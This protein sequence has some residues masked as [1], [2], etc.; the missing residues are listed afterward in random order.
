MSFVI[1]SFRYKRGYHPTGMQCL[2]EVEL[3]ILSQGDS[4]PAGM[5]CLT[6]VESQ[7]GNRPAGMQCLTEVELQ[8]LSQGDNR[9]PGMQCLTE[10]ESQGG[11]H[12]AGMQCLTE[13]E[14]NR[15]AG[16]QCLTEVELQILSQG[17]NRPAGMQCL[18]EVESQGDNCLMQC[19]TEV[20]SQGGNRPA[21]MQCLTEVES[22]GGNRP[23]GMQCESQGGNRPAGMQCLTEVESQEGNRPAGMQCLTEVESQGGN[24]PAGMQCLTEVELQ[25]LSQGSPE[26]LLFCINENEGKFLNTFKMHRYFTNSMHLKRMVKLLY[27]LVKCEDQNTALK[28]L[29]QIIC[30]DDDYAFFAIQIDGVLK[31]MI[32]ETCG[33]VKRENIAF[34]DHLIEIGSMGIKGIP[35]TVEMTFPVTMMERTLKELAATVTVMERTLTEL[36]AFG[37]N[38]ALIS[39]KFEKMKRQFDAMRGRFYVKSY[40]M[41]SGEPP[42]ECFTELPILPKRKKIHIQS[43][44]VFLRANKVK[45]GY[46]SSHCHECGRSGHGRNHGRHAGRR[47]GSRVHP[48]GMQC[49]SEEDLQTLS[50]GNP[51]EVLVSINK[52]EGRFLNTFKMRRY[53][54][55]P[56][57]LKRMVKLLYLLVKC[58]DQSTASKMMAQILCTDGDYASFTTQIDQVLKKMAFETRIYIKRDIAFLDNLIEIGSMAIKAI[59][60]TVGLTF[61]V[62]VMERTIEELTALGENTNLITMKFEEMNSAFKRVKFAAVIEAREKAKLE[63]SKESE[64]APP[65]PFTQLSVLPKREEIHVQSKKVFLRANK[66][67]GGYINCDHYFDVQFR[68]LREDFVRPLREGIG[69]FCDTGSTKKTSDIRVY[70][71]AKI[72]NPVCLFTGIGFQLRFD[73]SKFSRVNWEHSRRLIFGSLLCLSNDNFD[74]C[75]LFAT[76]VKRDPKLIQEGLLTIKFEG[77]VNGFQIDPTETYTMVES[78]AYY[79]AYCHV[80]KSMQEISLHPDAVPMKKYIMECDFTDVQVPVFLHPP[81]MP[82]HFN[83][84][85]ILGKRTAKGHLVLPRKVFNIANP[86]SW[87]QASSTCLDESQLRALKMALTKEVSVIQG[88]P[89][90]GKTYIGL[91]IVEAYLRNRAVWDP[92]RAAPILVVCYT[93]HT[94]DQLLEEIQKI[95]VD[96]ACPS[97]IRVGGRCKSAALENSVLSE[98][99]QE[100]RANRNIPQHLFRDFMDARSALFAS[101]GFINSN[102]K[103]CDAE[104]KQKIIHLFN[105]EVVIDPNHVDQLRYVSAMNKEIEVWLGLWFPEKEE[106]E[107]PEMAIL[108]PHQATHDEV[109]ALFPDTSSS[110]EEYIQVDNEARI[111]QEE[112]MI[113]GE[114]VEVPVRNHD[115]SQ[116]DDTALPKRSKKAGDKHGWKTVQLSESQ[117]K[118]KIG[119]GF[120]NTPMLREEASRVDNIWNLSDKERWQLYLHW[121]N[122]YIRCCKERV[123]TKAQEYNFTCMLYGESQRNIDCHVAQGADV[124]GMTT[125]GAA[126]YHHLLR[127]IHPKV[128]IFEEAAEVLEAHV[129]TSLAS[130]VQQLI[131]IGDHKQLKP[132]PTC[133]DLEKHYHLDTSLFERFINNGFEHVTLEKQHRMRPEISS[134]LCPSIYEKLEDAENVKKYDPVVGVGKDLFFIEHTHPEEPNEFSDMKSHVNKFEAEYVVELCHYLLK[135]GAYSPHDITILTMYRGQL[136]EL[137]KRMKREHFEGV[138]VAAV[139]DFQGEENE[140]ILLSLVRS[141]SDNSIG[142]LS[143]E[144]RVCVSLSRAKKGLYVIGNLCMLRERNDTKWPE[145]IHHLEN[146]QCVGPGLPLYC[147]VHPEDKAQIRTPA[148]F[149]QRPEGGCTKMC[150]MRLDCGHVCERICHPK[151]REHKLVSCSKVCGKNL[152][153]GHTCKAKCYQCKKKLRCRPC[154]EHVQ[155][156]LPYCGHTVTLR[157]SEDTLLTECPL[158]CQKSLPCGH[159][160]QNT[161]SV[162]CTI[163]CMKKVKKSLPCGHN[164]SVPCFE[165]P[166]F[167]VC[168]VKC[169]QMLECGDMCSGTCG[170]CHRGRLHI[171]CRQ[172]CGRDLVCGHLC[173]YQCAS[174]CPPCEEPCNN[175]CLHSK[176]P[177]KCY[178]LCKPCME[179]CEWLCP[180]LQCTKPCGELCNRPPCNK[181]CDKTLKC[182]HP[183]IGLCGERCPSKCRICDEDEVCAIFFGNED[184]EDALFI[185]LQ[186]CG[187]ILEVEGLDQW[188]ET[189]PGSN[190]SS[191]QVQFKTCPK[192]KAFIRKSVRYGN[193]IKQVLS[194]VEKVKHKQMEASDG[195]D[196]ELHKVKKQIQEIGS[197]SYISEDLEFINDH[198][199]NKANWY[200]CK[201]LKFQLTV[202]P[203]LVKV[204]Q[205]I[206]INLKKVSGIKVVGCTQM[207]LEDCLLDLKTFIMQEFLSSQE[208]SDG[209]S[210]LRRLT[211]AAKLLDLLCKIQMKKCVIT[212][213]E[214]NSIV[215][216]IKQAYFSGWNHVKTTKEEETAV[217]SFIRELSTKYQVDGAVGLSKGHW[218]KCPN[219]HVYCIG[220]CGGAMEKAKCP[221]CGSTIGGTNHSLAAGNLH[222]GEMDGSR[223]PAWS[224]AANLANFDPAD[225]ARLRL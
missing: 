50:Q 18:T 81:A 8:I 147:Q 169:E 185:Q 112:R 194:D 154:T 184:E 35:S 139:D 99:V 120:K 20:E 223:H 128:V 210:E 49:I 195:L 215:H 180:H 25:I 53:C 125:T 65:E 126:K 202:L 24:R 56:L 199:H 3:Q 225:L 16:M 115:R 113:Q 213:T 192:C 133:Y 149:R 28:M 146:E 75:L 122:E 91:K 79:E 72:L 150:G 220:D 76:V 12:P 163:K 46:S 205:I 189:D 47:C 57:H 136:L 109:A 2:T 198:I 132:K 172:K 62:T 186:D 54:H 148:E 55:H 104:S 100:C 51:V 160:C 203:R 39:T 101:Q 204:H 74:R 212:S 211:C 224:D 77:D 140:I 201:A 190:S 196:A 157:C 130:S 45:G 32:F 168:P 5:Q 166:S 134:L 11:N 207:Y 84:V 96:N 60:S 102:M 38:T 219:G 23:A 58:D 29:A 188:M 86:S 206:N 61:P 159:K 94:L 116:N 83:M 197:S 105:L 17:D 63:A 7:G 176:C 31:K 124:I 97:I 107:P 67:E 216:K 164:V 21:G 218:Y 170:K 27:L 4:R 118:K 127:Q 13:V 85:D 69:V 73:A 174:I 208:M 98:K 221:E 178:E 187:H 9:P 177:K 137:R 90:T 15:P 43:K 167:V 37:E 193:K 82:P 153:C 40:N 171:K 222:A 135:Q 141:N 143:I 155:K 200:R 144:N 191:K 183:C 95:M 110:D 44:K 36:A 22:Q 156:K 111:L 214:N 52:N 179:P 71:G 209:I 10:V 151:D 114:E 138:R 78:T 175:Y 173:K 181:R 152:P 19:L 66:I 123:N 88:P 121:T 142:F 93:T 33:Y 108:Q 68:L 64:G 14:S 80:L 119:K 161:C 182:G 103:N 42:A 145:I 162:G 59:P 1:G 165:D 117:K 217:N 89:G 158:P 129:I 106:A 87:P 34:L 48:A 6:E 70:E 131:M 26:E 30:A 41:E 92:Q